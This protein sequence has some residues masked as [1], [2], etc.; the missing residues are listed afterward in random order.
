MKIHTVGEKFSFHDY[1][2]FVGNIICGNNF[3]KVSECLLNRFVFYK[4]FKI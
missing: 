4:K 1:H 2:H 3:A